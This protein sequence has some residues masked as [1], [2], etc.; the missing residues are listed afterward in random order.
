MLILCLSINKNPL[1]IILTK[2]L[3]LHFLYNHTTETS[4]NDFM[5]SDVILIFSELECWSTVK[6][7]ICAGG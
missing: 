6:V 2:K 5:M 7:V 1:T 3:T 4:Y